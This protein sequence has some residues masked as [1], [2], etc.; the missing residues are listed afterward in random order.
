MVDFVD[1]TGEG[2][3]FDFVAS[4]YEALQASRLATYKQILSSLKVPFP[5]PEARLINWLR[6]VVSTQFT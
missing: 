1:S 5:L 4:M 2:V 3:E 6:S